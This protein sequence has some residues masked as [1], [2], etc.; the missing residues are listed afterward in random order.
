MLKNEGIWITT[1]QNYVDKNPINTTE[2]S[3]EIYFQVT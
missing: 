3:K 1:H 2:H